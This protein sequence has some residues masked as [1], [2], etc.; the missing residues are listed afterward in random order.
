MVLV[1]S[2][3]VPLGVAFTQTRQPRQCGWLPRAARQSPL[4]RPPCHHRTLRLAAVA[5]RE[6]PL[7]TAPRVAAGFRGMNERR[8]RRQTRW[9]GL[10]LV[11]K[12]QWRH[13]TWRALL[14]VDRQVVRRT[15]V[16]FSMTVA[17]VT[18]VLLVLLV[19]VMLTFRCGTKRFGL[20]RR[21]LGSKSVQ[22][23]AHE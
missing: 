13:G 16:R 23:D 20:F 12:F 22:W 10:Y 1:F 7:F 17:K 18:F 14:H 3:L 4:R 6:M 5:S 8:W 21:R 19:F 9:G 2:L 15:V 11:R